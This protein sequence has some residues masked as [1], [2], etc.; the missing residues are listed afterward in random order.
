PVAAYIASTPRFREEA[1]CLQ[2]GQDPR[3]QCLASVGITAG[4][5]YHPTPC[6]HTAISNPEVA[7][8]G[9]DFLFCVHLGKLNLAGGFLR[10]SWVDLAAQQ[11]IAQLI[12]YP[13]PGQEG[14]YLILHAAP[15]LLQTPNQGRRVSSSFR[16]SLPGP[17]GY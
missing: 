1:L 7:I 8:A 6:G 11:P 17:F 10:F 9:P 16:S 14:F 13:A 5:I 12:S 2:R 4:E 3:R 15:G